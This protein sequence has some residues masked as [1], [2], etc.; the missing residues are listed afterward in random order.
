M[1]LIVKFFTGFYEIVKEIQQ[2]RAEAI[3]RG[4]HWE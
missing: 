4:R 1:R 3:L 2:A